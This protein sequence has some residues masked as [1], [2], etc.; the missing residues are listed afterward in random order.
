MTDKRPFSSFL[1]S[2]G[3]YV[4]MQTTVSKIKRCQATEL[5]ELRYAQVVGLYRTLSEMG[6]CAFEAALY[7]D[8][9][10]TRDA[11]E[12]LQS[13]IDSRN[14]MAGPVDNAKETAQLRKSKRELERLEKLATVVS[15]LKT[16]M[17]QLHDGLERW[18]TSPLLASLDHVRGQ[19]MMKDAQSD[20]ER[21]EEAV[22]K[23]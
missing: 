9:E 6:V 1:A 23:V 15:E 22:N 16:G 17:D 18:V 11:I 20:F 7:H 5:P 13:T 3:N 4:V 12:D 14:A 21:Q 8:I 10:E 19:Q 2:S